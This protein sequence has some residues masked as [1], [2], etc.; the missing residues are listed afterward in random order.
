MDG[1][2]FAFT[3]TD[4]SNPARSLFLRKPSGGCTMADPCPGT[5][6]PAGHGG[7]QRPNWGVNQSAYNATI[8]W[9]NGGRAP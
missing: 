2:N 3:R 4:T 7:M 5:A 9:I 8:A 1:F 6:I